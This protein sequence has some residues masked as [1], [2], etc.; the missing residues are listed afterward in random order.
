M[1]L[2]TKDYLSQALRVDCMI[3]AKLE[4]I[5]QLRELREREKEKDTLKKRPLPATEKVE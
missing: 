4:Q 3:N 1:S 5:Q 2:N